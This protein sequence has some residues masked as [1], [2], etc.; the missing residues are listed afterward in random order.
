MHT[1]DMTHAYVWHDSCICVTW[2]MHTCD[3]TDLYVWHD[4]F[5]CVTW[6][7]HTCDMTHAHVW[8]DSFI[9]VTWLIHTCD[10]THSCI[11]HDSCIRKKV[12]SVNFHNYSTGRTP[13]MLLCWCECIMIQT[14]SCGVVHIFVQQGE[15]LLEMKLTSFLVFIVC[16]NKDTG[17]TTQRVFCVLSVCVYVC[18]RAC[19]GH[20][21]NTPGEPSWWPSTPSLSAR[22][23][24]GT[25]VSQD[26]CKLIWLVFWS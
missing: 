2:L 11:W 15:S 23:R 13:D 5:I 3:M 4:S 10:M 18:V 12:K 20:V 16:H 7:M 25:W 8:H 1:C 17:N 24:V 26:D 22:P 6:L 21:A 14:W 9:C 19:G